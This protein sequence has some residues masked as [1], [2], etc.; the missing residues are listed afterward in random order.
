M[1]FKYG[2]E[3]FII[4]WFCAVIYLMRI[5]QTNTK[6]D[7]NSDFETRRLAFASIVLS[8]LGLIFVFVVGVYFFMP[9]PEIGK[10]FP[11]KDIF[12]SAKTIIPP[13]ITLVLGYYFGQSNIEIGKNAK[14]KEKHNKK[15]NEAPSE[16]DAA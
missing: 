11:A 14:K 15:Q 1:E 4:L 7:T 16:S 5:A 6:T 13:I 12:E 2:M 9:A 10:E 3:M 8:G